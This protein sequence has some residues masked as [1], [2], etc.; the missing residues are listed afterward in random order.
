MGAVQEIF[1]A[2][3]VCCTKT[4][5]VSSNNWFNTHAFN[6]AHCAISG[7]VV[8]YPDF[9]VRI[10]VGDGLNASFDVFLSIECHYDV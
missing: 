3:I 10:V 6:C 4:Q 5:I 2:K 7:T 1:E 9:G 8:V